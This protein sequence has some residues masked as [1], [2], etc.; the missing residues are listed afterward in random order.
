[1]VDP[2][3][4]QYHWDLGNRLLGAGDA[5]GAVAELQ[6][7]ADLGETEPQLYV[8]LGDERRRLGEIAAARQDYQRALFIDPYYAPAQQRLTSLGS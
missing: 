8:D 7:A 3:Q 4:A 6:R 1:R 5:R 2:L